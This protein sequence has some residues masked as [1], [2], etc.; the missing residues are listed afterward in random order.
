MAARFCSRE[1]TYAAQPAA[2][3]ARQARVKETPH[4]ESQATVEST[5]QKPER[6]QK[7]RRWVRF[8][9]ESADHISPIVRLVTIAEIPE[10][11]TIKVGEA[12]RAATAAFPNFP[13]T[14][15]PTLANPNPNPNAAPTATSSTLTRNKRSKQGK[16]NRMANKAAAIDPVYIPPHL[17]KKSAPMPN[18]QSTTQAQQQKAT[19]PKDASAS[20]PNPST[21]NIAV[22]HNGQPPATPAHQQKVNGPQEI[23]TASSKPH[24]GSTN[25][26][27]NHPLSPPSPPSS[28]IKSAQPAQPAD[29]EIVWGDWSGPRADPVE[30]PAK[31]NGMAK[32]RWN[33]TT[34]MKTKWA[35]AP[36]AW[37]KNRDMRPLPP[38]D[39]SD[40]GVTFKSHSNGDPHY[41][42]KKLVD[43]NGDWLPAPV[44][45]AGRK[46]FHDRHF[47]ENIEAWMIRCEMI[48]QDEIDVQSYPEWLSGKCQIAPPNWIPLRIEMDASQNF[49]RAHPSRAPEPLD[50]GDMSELPW[51]EKYIDLEKGVLVNSE[52]PDVELDMG[53]DE[54]KHPGREVSSSEAMFRK[55]YARRA[56]EAKILAKRNRPVAPLGPNP[57]D[58]RK[59]KPTAHIHLRPVRPSDISQIT[60][61]YNYYIE[62]TISTAEFTKHTVT[63]ITD[64]I[65][66]ITRCGLPWIVAVAPGAPGKARQAYVEDTIVGFAALDDYYDVGSSFRYTYKCEM[67]VHND[68]LHH[69]IGKC[70]MDRLLFLVDPGY[71]LRGGYDWKN[72]GE[73]LKTGAGRRVKTVIINFPHVQESNV[74]LDQ[75]TAFSKAFGWR[76]GGHLYDMGYKYGQTIDCTIFQYKTTEQIEAAMRP[77]PL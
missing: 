41:D 31:A 70:L 69:G 16:R 74:I 22:T 58:E 4:G 75:F 50:A 76:K 42:I 43:W 49:W 68:F 55:E 73:Y 18:S 46:S 63:Q 12:P 20:S 45:W 65:D 5:A 56:K 19:G 37:P 48:P 71:A 15:S 60:D 25:A 34:G 33:N 66:K 27:A 14:T 24:T 3:L 30:E 26:A 40:G 23:S 6:K 52:V 57:G 61:I 17:R 59:L 53:E 29:E 11:L 13:P 35:K 39:K 72:D 10:R 8:D 32:S 9:P 38:D 7:S 77:L 21:S 47:A 64:R 51:W 1:A 36:R 44:E 28:S 2:T 62:N 54:N 67:F